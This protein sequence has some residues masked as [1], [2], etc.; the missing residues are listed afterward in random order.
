MRSIPVYIHLT[1]FSVPP[2][3]V[4]TG[5][6]LAIVII[7]QC[8]ALKWQLQLSTWLVESGCRYMMAWGENCSSW[9][10]SVDMANLEAFDYGDIPD[11]QFVMTT[12]HENE[13]LGDVFWFAKY[14]ASHPTIEL[15]Q[16]II[17][18][19]AASSALDSMLRD[20]EAA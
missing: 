5:P 4:I 14:A 10:D 7:E 6:F 11:D 1:P 17:V 2:P 8:V 3:S 13:P 20:Y 18:H 12:W 19:L 15:E 16:V 9:D